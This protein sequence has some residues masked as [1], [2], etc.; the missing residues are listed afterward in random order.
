MLPLILFGV[1]AVV[2]VWD[3]NNQPIT[4]HVDKEP[5]ELKGVKLDGH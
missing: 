5:F 1:A 3:F 4:K 2:L